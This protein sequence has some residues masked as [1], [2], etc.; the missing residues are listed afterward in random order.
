MKQNIRSHF[1]GNY[2]PFFDKYLQ[3]TKQIGRNEFKAICPFHKDTN[4][5]LNFNNQSGQ[6]YCHG[7]GNRGDIFH[8]YGKINDLETRN[9]FPKI[10]K[11][12]SDDFSI[13]LEQQKSRIVKTYDYTDT[14]DNLL[15]QVCR[16]EPK[17]FCQ[18]Q[19][20]TDGKWTW[21]LKGIEPVL[22]QL[23]KILKATEV[24]VVEGEKDADN[25]FSLG[26][27]ATTSPMGAK[28]WKPKYNDSLKG[29]NVVLIPDN[30]NEGREHMTRV[31]RSLN[32]N[33]KSLKWID[34]PD[35]PSK[36]D[37][38]DYIAKFNDKEQATE[39]LSILIDNAGPYEPSKK[40]TI[41]DIILTASDFYQLNVSERQ[42]F[43]FPWLKE[44]SINLVSGWRGCGKTWFALG[45]LD[46][47]TRGESFG[48]WKCKKPVPCLFLDGEMTV[49]DDHER[50]KNLRLDSYRENLLYFY[51][52]AYANQLG[53]QRAHLADESWRKKMKQILITQKVK[54]WVVDNL[55]S[56]A[57]GLD[58]NSKKD[59]DPINSWLLELRF[60]GIATIM[61]HHV[62][63]KGGQRG[64]S[65]RE[66]N[67]D[68]SLM[69]KKPH[70]YTPKDGARFIVHFSK[71][72]VSTSKLNLIGDTEF[73]LIINESGNHVWTFGSVRKETKNEI[74]RLLD[75]GK[76]QTDIKN[77]LGIDKGYVSRIRK[78]AI[79]DGLLT[80]KNKLT[81]SGFMDVN[82]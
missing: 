21:N 7:C 31:A 53:L 69:L 44:D 74:L 68:I 59:W 37:V 62:N 48:P 15:F 18:R 56:L 49:T 61:L 22:Y 45:V 54:L 41:E 3:K 32:G 33:A 40:I 50:I 26:F 64:T 82:G 28:K 58:E 71:A 66:D 11:G 2:K 19:L 55:A 47:V 17:G 38:S 30:D 73:K 6:Y 63:K 75:E 20:G 9:G 46:A 80:S 78:Q 10:L 5:S 13:P 79:K 76:T 14:S 4:P 72:R 24:L 43:L 42:E 12:I 36:G 70:D 57:S 35:L 27:T 67:L 60:A 29:K 39:Q 25:L 51:S 1:S 23:P 34:L 65:A 8:F 16:M 77:T 81:Q 52:D